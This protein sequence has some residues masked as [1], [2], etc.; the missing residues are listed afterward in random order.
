M[1]KF[2]TDVRVVIDNAEIGL[3]TGAIA[4]FMVVDLGRFEFPGPV[5]MLDL[6]VLLYENRENIR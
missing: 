2:M 4:E 6:D 1:R 5:I 3:F